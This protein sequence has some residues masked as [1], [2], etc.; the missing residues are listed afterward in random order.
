MTCKYEK[1]GLKVK[2]LKNINKED[3]F[4]I[5]PNFTPTTIERTQVHSNSYKKGVKIRRKNH[6][7]TLHY[8]G[9]ISLMN[10]S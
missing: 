8:P 5:R 9:D 1:E 4:G 7:P 2:N 6:H 10:R 3:F